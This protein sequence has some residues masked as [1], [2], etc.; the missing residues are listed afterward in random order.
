MTTLMRGRDVK[1]GD[2][3]IFLGTPHR[4]TRI[5]P[6]R[7]SLNDELFGREGRVAYS[8]TAASACRAAWGITLDPDG[9]YE[10]SR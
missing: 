9:T 8:D 5:E 4:I 1:A 7:G 6:Y 10:I 3:L 2:D